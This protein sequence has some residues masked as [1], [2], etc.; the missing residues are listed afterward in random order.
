MRLTDYV[1]IFYGC[2]RIDEKPEGSLAHKWNMLKGKAANTSPAAMIPFGNV[3]CSPYSG[4]YPMGYGNNMINSGEKVEELFDA[5]KIIGFSHFTHSGTGGVGFYYN[6]FLTTPFKTSLE[7]TPR[8]KTFCN[9]VA[10]PGKYSCDI[11]YENISCEL[12]VYDSV[13]IHRYNGNGENFDV[14]IDVVNDGLERNDARMAKHTNHKLYSFAKDGYVEKIDKNRVEG[15]AL[16]QGVKIFFAIQVETENCDNYLWR[17]YKKVEGDK[18]VLD[19]NDVKAG[20]VFNCSENAVLK[21]AFSFTD[22]ATAWKK[23]NTAPCFD[24]CVRLA[25]DTWEKTLGKIEIDANEKDK[26]KFY[27]CMYHSLVKPCKWQKESFLWDDEQGDFYVDFT[28]MWDV[29]KTQLP[30]IFALYKD[31]ADGIVHTMDSFS[32]HNDTLFNSILISEKYNIATE[33]AACL[34][35]YSLIDAHYRGIITDAEKVLSVSKKEV[36]RFEKDVLNGTMEKTTKLLDVCIVSY[37]LYLIAKENGLKEYADFYKEIAEHWVD[38]FGENGLLKTNYEYYEGNHYNYSFRFVNDV[39]KRIE[40]GGGKENLIKTLDK[41]FAL[42]INDDIDNRFEGFNNETDMETPYFYHYVGEY[43]KLCRIVRE[44]VDVCFTEGRGA[45]PGNND[46]G[47]LSTCFMWNYIG[48][49]PASGLDYMFLGYP[50][51]NKTTLHLWNGNTLVINA[52]GSGDTIE[53]VTLNGKVVD[54]YKITVKDFMQG[55]TLDFYKK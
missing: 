36:Q 25:E 35:C 6:Y 52:I 45:I 28:T 33:Q 10:K 53:K 54:D 43:D 40:I 34:C 49:F 5:D 55:G 37:Q 23:L 38:A 47:A 24:E 11:K 46:S 29:Y 3:A 32:I 30:L 21:I 44:C 1:D 17:D 16:L 15:Y 19:G 39:E 8:H 14:S 41:F 51:S 13:A 27:S 31:V 22:V 4:G 42:D 2:G 20:C 26:R 18:L 7:K 48:L 9:E 12:T 50:M